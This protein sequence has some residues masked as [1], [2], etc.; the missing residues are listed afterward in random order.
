M[1]DTGVL[2]DYTKADASYRTIPLP[3]RLAAYLDQYCLFYHGFDLHDPD[4]ARG[5]IPIVVNSAGRSLDGSFLP[6]RPTTLMQQLIAAR[7]PAGM[8]HEQMGFT[9]GNHYFRECFVTEVLN[10]A[11]ILAD[12]ERRTVKEA[13]ADLAERVTFLENLINR[14]D[15]TEYSP[16]HV[17]SYVGHIHDQKSE[18]EAA[19]SVTLQRYNLSLDTD[20][21][22][23]AISEAMDRLIEMTIG[24]LV[25]EPDEWDLM[26]AHLLDDPEWCTVVEAVELIG[27]HDSTVIAAISDGRLDG[28]M[29]WQA[30]GGYLRNERGTGRST[31]ALPQLFV[32]RTSI[33]EFI[34]KKDFIGTVPAA[35]RFGMSDWPARRIL[36]RAGYQPEGTKWSPDAVDD[37]QRRLHQLLLDALDESPLSLKA[38][39]QRIDATQPPLLPDGKVTLGWLETWRDQLLEA[40]A[41]TVTRDGFLGRRH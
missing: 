2:L 11:V 38:I 39:K 26:P 22:L 33:K 41:I 6:I 32:S 16:M 40:K 36:L 23:L 7:V 28:H 35:K 9:V 31:P 17:S 18:L 30:N 14:R 34:R 13:P 1:S 27:V 4:R 12:L 3:R 37:V 21:P 10:M 24:D 29:G 15:I 25:F 19:A 5:H 8:T 20:G